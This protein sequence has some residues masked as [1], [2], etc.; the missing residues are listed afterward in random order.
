M[1]RKN[2]GFTIMELL[3]AITILGI[4][5]TITI[6][7]VMNVMN[8]QRNKKYV[9]DSIRLISAAD[10][11]MR[12][13]NKMPVPPINSCVVM[14]LVYLDDVTFEEAPLGG[15]YDKM[16]SFVVAK[17]NYE[18]YDEDY[19]YYV[20][21]VEKT[22]AG[23]YRG[24]NFTEVNNL[25]KEKAEDSYVVNL[26]SDKISPLKS[27]TSHTLR[28]FLNNTYGIYCQNLYIYAPDEINK[29]GA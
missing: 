8:N 18:G 9:E 27:Y 20:R 7:I 29:E 4:M 2:L 10:Y 25:Y 1:P 19:L 12:N 22:K 5:V 21:L 23:S 3:A 24:I 13:D 28:N 16:V 15:K 14:S 17:R 6:P 11:K 26:T